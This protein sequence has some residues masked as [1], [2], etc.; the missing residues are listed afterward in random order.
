MEN[1]NS[2]TDKELLKLQVEKLRLENEQKKIESEK[3][4]SNVWG[5]ILMLIIFAIAAYFIYREYNDSEIKKENPFY[6]MR[7]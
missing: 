2:E 6:K 7:E 3:Q 1:T 5:S 4:Q